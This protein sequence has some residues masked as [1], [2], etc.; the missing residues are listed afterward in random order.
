MLISE[1]II[2]SLFSILGLSIKLAEAVAKEKGKRK[3]EG[4]RE[5][6]KIVLKI[7]LI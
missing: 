7:N 4:G 3:I 1:K 5:A 2:S 6:G